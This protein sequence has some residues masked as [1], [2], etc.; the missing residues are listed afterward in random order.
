[1]SNR[2]LAL[3]LPN[4]GDPQSQNGSFQNRTS[5]NR[6]G[7][8]TVVWALC[9]LL[10]VFGPFAATG[11]SKG[12]ERS[13]VNVR[14]M[15]GTTL[16]G[17]VDRSSSDEFLHMRFESGSAV[18]IRKIPWNHIQH[19]SVD[20]EPVPLDRFRSEYSQYAV[21]APRPINSS[22]RFVISRP[23]EQ[24]AERGSA[25]VHRRVTHIRADAWPDNWDADS[26]YD[27]LRLELT[28]LDTN[29][30]PVE[31]NGT[32]MAELYAS[33]AKRFHEVP[34]SRGQVIS[35]I[36]RWYKPVRADSFSRGS[37]TFKLPMQAVHPDH[38]SAIGTWGLVRIR[39]SVPG[40][41]VFETSVDTVRIRTISPLQVRLK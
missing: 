35:Q 5:Q 34:R 27:G 32:I 7:V 8:P 13:T 29:D 24:Q 10:G 20:G 40:Q 6:A 1:M 16:R 11:T 39:L 30:Q 19:V 33:E 38:N 12:A 14:L 18:A 22:H 26:D 4:D 21:T 25:P 41:G 9:V 36:A 37:I 2:T 23:G 17:Q 28:P 3:K 31:V 15:V